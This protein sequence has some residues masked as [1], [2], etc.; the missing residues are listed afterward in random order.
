LQYPP[1]ATTCLFPV[2]FWMVPVPAWSFCKAALLF[3]LM[4]P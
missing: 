2:K 3:A 1:S 4:Y